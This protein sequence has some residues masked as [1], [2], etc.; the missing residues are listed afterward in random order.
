MPSA[1]FLLALSEHFSS[2]RPHNRR[3]GSRGQIPKWAL[4]PATS[5]GSV[6]AMLRIAR[7]SVSA[8]QIGEGRRADRCVSHSL[9]NRC[10]CTG[11]ARQRLGRGTPCVSAG[12]ETVK[13]GAPDKALF[14]C[15][16]ACPIVKNR[17]SE[18]RLV[19]GTPR[20]VPFAYSVGEPKPHEG[21]SPKR[22]KRRNAKRVRARR[23]PARHQP[24]AAAGGLGEALPARH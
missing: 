19:R 13:T 2:L 1:T 7:V 12:R 5:R 14:P 22:P 18:Q 20:D 21:L 3:G 17:T 23:G 10:G 9:C 24:P 16:A 6:T 4:C 8:S 15:P 11:Q